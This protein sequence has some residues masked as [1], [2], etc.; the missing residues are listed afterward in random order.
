MKTS[1]FLSL[2]QVKSE[3][4]KALL[5]SYFLLCTVL[6]PSPIICSSSLLLPVFDSIHDLKILVWTFY[7]T[8]FCLPSPLFLLPLP[9]PYFP[10]SL[11]SFPL[12]IEFLRL[13]TWKALCIGEFMQQ[14]KDYWLLFE[15]Q[16]IHYV[17]L[18]LAGKMFILNTMC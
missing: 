6:C 15:S 13:F 10:K 1:C 18:E 5:I 3:S 4:I 12:L 9:L 16:S 11:H 8:Y 2:P 7:K 17:Y 14:N